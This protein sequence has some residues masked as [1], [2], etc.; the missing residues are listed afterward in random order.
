MIDA[1]WS[2]WLKT[3]NQA[4]NTPCLVAVR[5]NASETP[6]LSG[7]FTVRF[8]RPFLSERYTDDSRCVFA[9]FDVW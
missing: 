2:P 4:V 7:E 8:C 6:R 3:T 9:T 5:F 1:L